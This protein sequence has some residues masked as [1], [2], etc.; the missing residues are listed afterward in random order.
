MLAEEE[1]V[2]VDMSGFVA[3][4]RMNELRAIADEQYASVCT[5]LMAL[6]D[7]LDQE[8][9]DTLE[10]TIFDIVSQAGDDFASE[11]DRFAAAGGSAALENGLQARIIRYGDDLIYVGI[12]LILAGLVVFFYP[13]LIKKLGVPRMIIGLFFVLLCVVALLYDLSLSGLMSNTLVRMG[14]NSILVLAMVPGIQCGI[15]L[16]LG[17]PIGIVGGLIGGLLAIEWQIGGWL[18]FLFACVV[19]MAI[20]A[21]TGALYGMLLNRLK[22]SEMSVTTYVGFSIVSLMCIAWLVLPFN[23]LELRWPLGTGLRNTIVMSDSTSF[24]HLLD[25]FLSFSIGG[26]RFRRAFCCSWCCAAIW[27]GCSCARARAWR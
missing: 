10:S 2:E 27:C 18:G 5:E 21:V 16:N 15:G 3:T 4:E 12:G 20:S 1:E 7:T 11:Y 6:Y 8:A 17:L 9:L 24:G 23:S 25:N 19:G 14:M 26:S 13:A 22:G